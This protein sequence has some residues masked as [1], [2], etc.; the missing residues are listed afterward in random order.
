M[1]PQHRRQAF[2]MPR[3][4]RGKVMMSSVHDQFMSA[5]V[6]RN[7]ARF[8]ELVN[9][10][11]LIGSKETVNQ[12]DPGGRTPLSHLCGHG[13]HRCVEDFARLKLVDV[14]LGDKDG[15]TPLHYAAQAG[16]SEVVD[17]L[18]S[19]FEGIEVDARNRLGITPLIKACVTGKQKCVQILLDKGADPLVRDPRRGLT[20]AQ[21][22]HLC[23]WPACARVLQAH[24]MATD[25]DLRA[26]RTPVPNS[27]TVRR[28]TAVTNGELST[29]TAAE[30][31]PDTG[32]ESAV[33]PC[34]Q[35]TAAE[36][37][38]CPDLSEDSGIDPDSVK[39]SGPEQDCDAVLHSEPATEVPESSECQESR[40]LQWFSESDLTREPAWLRERHTALT[41]GGTPSRRASLPDRPDIYRPVE[42][43]TWRT[44]LEVPAIR[45][46]EVEAPVD[47]VIVQYGDPVPPDQLAVQPNK[48]KTLCLPGMGKGFAYE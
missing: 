8:R 39:N 28:P 14:N 21:W 41:G 13:S 6:Q 26:G 15:N 3:Q 9:R 23:S 19:K 32:P 18:L 42:P 24:A 1:T 43:A 44:K 5:C 37:C 31:D 10:V 35:P 36:T 46:R 47:P 20:A 27:V 29:D 7:E 17:V 25:T 45:V 11:R 22:A 4:G 30:P 2:G 48:V 33:D 16:H 38:P 34:F 12:T 40:L